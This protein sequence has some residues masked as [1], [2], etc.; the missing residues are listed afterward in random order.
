[1]LKRRVDATVFFIHSVG[2][3]QARYLLCAI[4]FFLLLISFISSRRYRFSNKSPK[5]IHSKELR[6][7]FSSH[8]ETFF[9]SNHENRFLTSISFF[10]SAFGIFVQ[11]FFFLLFLHSTNVICDY[12]SLRQTGIN[13]KYLGQKQRLRS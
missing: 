8:F 13:I 1:M 11:L 3:S 2:R 12:V 9:C 6:M 5:L 4:F 10:I 7:I